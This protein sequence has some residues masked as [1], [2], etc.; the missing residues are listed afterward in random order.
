[1][2]GGQAHTI[3]AVALS[4]HFLL[5]LL[6]LLVC[7][8]EYCACSVQ[9]TC[10]AEVLDVIQA[11]QFLDSSEYQSTPQLDNTFKV[12]YA[13]PNPTNNLL[14]LPLCTASFRLSVSLLDPGI[15]RIRKWRTRE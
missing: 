11:G 10:D 15:C 1:V 12:G 3:A 2:H 5:L 14:L 13:S 9:V 7:V 4:E 6:L 8:V